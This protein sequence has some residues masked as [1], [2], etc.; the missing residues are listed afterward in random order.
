MTKAPKDSNENE[1]NEDAEEEVFLKKRSALA[2]L[3]STKSGKVNSYRGNT[4]GKRHFWCD[5]WCKTPI[6]TNNHNND[7]RK[8]A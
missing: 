5:H 6:E 7:K 3:P 1:E 4:Y 2:P 8:C